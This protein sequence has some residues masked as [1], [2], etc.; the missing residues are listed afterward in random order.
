MKEE[1]H[2]VDYVLVSS[3][4]RI[5]YEKSKCITFADLLLKIPVESTQVKAVEQEKAM[6]FSTRLRKHYNPS[7]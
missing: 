3:H 5:P 2:D 1:Y 7:F 4:D 6:D